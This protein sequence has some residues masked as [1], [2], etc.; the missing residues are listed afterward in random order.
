MTA[1]LD[2]PA[3]NA[4]PLAPAR[5]G[6]SWIPDLSRFNGPRYK[7]IADA[8]AADIEQNRLPS[9]TRLPTHRDL[10]YRLKVT[11]GTVTRAYSEAEKRGLIGGEV[12]RG[13]FVRPRLEPVTAQALNPADDLIDLAINVSANNVGSEAES[14]SRT[15][16]DISLSGA[17]QPFLSY[18][19][20]LGMPAHR[21]AMAQFIARPGFT[22]EPET[23]F[24]TS[25]AQHA[26]LMALSAVAA[27]GDTI[28]CDTLTYGGLKSAAR[29]MHLRTKGLP[30]DEAGI[31]PEAFEAACREGL[32]KALYCMPTI[33]NPTAIIWSATR[34]AEIAAL[35]QRYRVAI[36]EDD[37]YGF[38][39]PEAPLPL[40]AYA[41]DQVYYLSSTSKSLA[42]GLRIGALVAPGDAAARIASGV[43]TT[44]WMAPPLMAEIV[45]RWVEDGTAQRLIEEK[46]I[47]GTAR[48]ALARQA[49]GAYGLIPR[50][51]HPNA[52]H[53]WL[54]LPEGWRDDVLLPAARREGVIL[55]PTSAFCVGRTVS[56]GV[57][58]ALGTPRSRADVV[59]GFD[60]LGRLLGA[61]RK[62]ADLAVEE[63]VI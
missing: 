17:V 26:L 63:S 47:E 3:R 11:V 56:D 31:V 36:L 54:D 20:H 51:C 40:H 28:A 27:P 12:G 46:R 59:R 33:Q 30:S 45:R 32:V 38:L 35:A 19:P 14:L 53:M 57:R 61:N 55:S 8:L 4:G 29:L 10:A 34:R 52:Y 6:D 9:G 43:R 50:A 39:V 7:A 25:G 42:A 22:P 41:P 37:V 2:A 48:Q 21:A 13:T 49:L 18:Q 23:V 60:I 62:A 16:T 24:L 5:S 1:L 44:V 15:L 58:V